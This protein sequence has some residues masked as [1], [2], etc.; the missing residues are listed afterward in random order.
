MST[1]S[2]NRHNIESY[3]SL[4][5]LPTTL[6]FLFQGTLKDS[7]DR[8]SLYGLEENASYECNFKNEIEDV[9]KLVSIYS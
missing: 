9:I 1:G 5:W 4:F 3:W 7:L 2:P 8:Y 6:L